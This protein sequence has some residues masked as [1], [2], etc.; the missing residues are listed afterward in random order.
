MPR[1]AATTAGRGLRRPDRDFLLPAV[2]MAAAAA[3]LLLVL[4]SDHVGA[5]GHDGHAAASHVHGDA[6]SSGT[7][8]GTSAGL[9]GW[10]LMVVA[11]MLPPALPLLRML[12]RLVARHRGRRVLVLSGGA[13]F[14]AVWMLLGLLLVSGDAVLTALTGGAWRPAAPVLVGAVLLLAGAFQ[15]SPLKSRCLVACRSPRS[16]AVAHWHG[17]RHPAIESA[18]VGAAYGASCVG[19][20]WALMLVC[21]AGGTAHLVTMVPLTVLMTAERMT[22][23]GTSLVRP[24]G[25]AALVAGA[26]L[27]AV[28]VLGT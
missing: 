24:I 21:F 8:A 25:V 15:L 6:P 7:G 27:L 19:C 26:G 9:I 20:C 23:F 16:F 3:W 11:M 2:L 13:S 14:L 22:P 18:T 1:S 12:Q 28:P 4:W 17:E 10:F 5:P